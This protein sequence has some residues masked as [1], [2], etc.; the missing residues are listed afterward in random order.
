V[1]NLRELF[2]VLAFLV[3]GA[4]NAN[5]G[6][7]VI[8]GAALINS[9]QQVVAWGQQFVQMKSQI[10][11]MESQFNSMNGSRGI[12]SLLKNPQLYDYAPHDFATV[13]SADGSGGVGAS[14]TMT[15]LKLYGIEQTSINPNSDTGK[16]FKNGQNQNA[17][18]RMVGEQGYKAMNDR[19]GQ[20]SSL[21]QSIDGAS[22]PKA[23]ADLQ[24]RISAEQAF[25]QNE[26]TKLNVIA[27]MQAGQERI[28]QQQGREILMKSSQGVVPRF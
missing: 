1:K 27:Q 10:T 13:L 14:S 6:I 3:G 18:F 25:I 5:A 19:I 26:Q 4:S 9:A 2:I 17:V 21:T 12:A 28:R 11:Q 22:D 7:P 8:D 16:F 24:V 15:S 20:L 23:I